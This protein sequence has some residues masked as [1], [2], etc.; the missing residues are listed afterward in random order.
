M[1]LTTTGLL[2]R[3]PEMLVGIKR[4]ATSG[5]GCAASGAIQGSVLHSTGPTDWR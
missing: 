2:R 3:R 5:I 1:A 4:R